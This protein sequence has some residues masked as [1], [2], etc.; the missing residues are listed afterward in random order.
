MIDRLPLERMQRIFGDVT[1]EQVARMTDTERSKKLREYSYKVT[2]IANKRLGRFE[3]TGVTSPAYRHWMDD[4]GGVRFGIRGMDD[5]GVVREIQRA[6]RFNQMQTS[7]V[8]GATNH[9]TQIGERLGLEVTDRLEIQEMSSRVFEITSKLDQLMKTD[10]GKS[11]GSEV[12]Q[13]YV[14]EFMQTH[15]IEGMDNDDI[16]AMIY[17]YDISGDIR[18]QTMGGVREELETNEALKE[19]GSFLL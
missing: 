4:G 7:T 19:F 11:E 10:G 3:E 14:S 17:S 15:D 13:R 12:L 5:D 16:L 8:R 6:E 1:R 9:I 2:N 18:E